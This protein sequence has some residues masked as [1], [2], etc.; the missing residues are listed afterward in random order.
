MPQWNIT[1]LDATQ[2]L[3]T[4]HFSTQNKLTSTNTITNSLHTLLQNKFKNFYLS[5]WALLVFVLVFLF[6]FMFLMPILML[7]FISVFV[8]MLWLVLFLNMFLS[9]SIGDSI[10]N[11]VSI[12]Q[13][14]QSR[15]YNYKV[16]QNTYWSQPFTFLWTHRLVWGIGFTLFLKLGLYIF[17]LSAYKS[18]G[19]KLKVREPSLT[20]GWLVPVH[21]PVFF[22]FSFL[23]LSQ[24]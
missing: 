14:R 17:F 19:L 21:T 16:F 8:F 20:S 5:T 4:N 11:H 1:A 15:L 22:R 13:K 9:I 10:H 12:C 7:V 18:K 3:W 23:K 6:V 24:K 2:A